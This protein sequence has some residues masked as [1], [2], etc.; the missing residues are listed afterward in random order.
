VISVPVEVETEGVGF[1]GERFARRKREDSL[2]EGERRMGERE[3]WVGVKNN[4]KKEN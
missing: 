4:K 3:K 2:G 1:L